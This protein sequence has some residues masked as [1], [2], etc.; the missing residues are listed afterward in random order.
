[1]QKPLWRRFY[2][3]YP[4]L[5]LVFLILF[6]GA[7]HL[8]LNHP[9][10]QRYVI[11][12]VNNYMGIQASWQDLSFNAL[13]GNFTGKDLQLTLKDKT[14]IELDRFE[15]SF[16]P[17]K[18]LVK[19]IHLRNIQA[20]GVRI[21]LSPEKKHSKKIPKN[22]KPLSLPQIQT[23]KLAKLFSMIRL[24]Q[25]SLNKV[26][27][28]IDENKTLFVENINVTSQ[29]NLYFFGRT[30]TT[31]LTHFDYRSKKLDL[32]I[33]E[34]KFQGSID[35][36]INQEGQVSKPNL[37]ALLNAQ[38]VLIGLNKKPSPWNEN[39]AW[40]NRL[41]QLIA[42]YFRQPPENRAF[43]YVRSF[44]L[45]ITLN[46]QQFVI[47]EA[48]FDAFGGRLWADVNYNLAKNLLAAKIKTERDFQLSLMPLGKAV[49]RHS[50]RWAW[51]DI[52]LQGRGIKNWRP[53]DLKDL[54]LQG[55]AQL[56]LKG[57]KIEVDGPDT[58]LNLKFLA[59]SKKVKISQINGKLLGLLTGNAQFDWQTKKLT[60]K[61]SAQGLDSQTV[62][63]LFTRQKIGGLANAKG[64]IFGELTNPSFDLELA[65]DNLSYQKLSVGNFSGRLRIKNHE[66][67][68]TGD[69][70]HGA[71]S[72][73]KLD[74]KLKEVFRPSKQTMILQVNFAQMPI[75]KVVADTQTLKGNIT[76]D[77]SLKRLSYNE[78]QASGKVRLEPFSWYEVDFQSI[79]AIVKQKDKTLWL[80]PIQ[81]VWKSTGQK[82][83]ANGALV[84][85]FDDQGYRFEGPVLQNTTIKGE[86]LKARP[87]SLPIEVVTKNH[88]LDFLTPFFDK[89]ITKSNI[90][91]RLLIDFPILHQAKPKYQAFLDDLAIEFNDQTIKL[92]A[93][94]QWRVTNQRFEFD[95][96]KIELGGLPL[97][98]RGSY[99]E[100][101]EFN[102]NLLGT[103]NT[104]QLIGWQPWLIDAS[105]KAEVKLE[106]SGDPKNPIVNGGV[107]FDKANLSFRNLRSEINRLTGHLE[108]KGNRVRFDKVKFDYDDSPIDLDGWIEWIA[109]QQILAAD[110]KI[111]AKELL[112]FEP[113]T[114]R[115]LIDGNYYLRGQGKGLT[116][117]GQAFL[118]EG[119][120]YKDYNLVENFL[121]PKTQN[122]LNKK[123]I[124]DLFSPINLSVNLK[125]SGTFEIR[126]NLTD[127]VLA[128]ELNIEGTVGN[129]IF[130]GNIN[131]VEGAIHAL[132]FD[133][134]DA[135]GFI[136]FDYKQK[137]INPY[138]EMIA[139]QEIQ[140]YEI[141]ALING[142]MDNL[143]FSLESTP[144]LN[145]KEILSLIIYGSTPDQLSTQKR[146]LF[147]RTAIASQVIGAVQRP[148]SK[149]TGLDIIKLKPNEDPFN[150]NFSKLSIG[151]QITDRFTIA[152]TTELDL[153]TA[154]RGITLEYLVLDNLLLKS[155]TDG[156]S[157]YRFDVTWRFE[158]F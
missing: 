62:F 56:K 124:P 121:K 126:N 86:Y 103:V 10:L 78:Y 65:S 112:F 25:G 80:G 8:V 136:S 60:S 142:R 154:N 76:G 110:L 137:T 69:A 9:K 116:L 83:Q 94:A 37:K 22:K 54:A 128:P 143:K 20:T 90:S 131:I 130:R 91:G 96:T 115:V 155:T 109:F 13:G 97:Q 52:E 133:F 158:L 61:L 85:R 3:F 108:L 77:Y 113:Q 148:L 32:I 102:L 12:K 71:G 150:E 59:D 120:Y 147:S 75:E 89:P 68:L 1:M 129:P 98:F 58:E 23:Q 146:N 51:L 44:D 57:N 82:E 30:V 118:V 53:V 48:T 88:H 127:L 79:S 123:K 33:P 106:I 31:Q 107:D 5:L 92:I 99:Q 145:Q 140:E 29:K 55:M 42:Q 74:L 117:S 114:W 39:P 139:T 46:R 101:K 153:D 105:G 16:Q 122:I 43:V 34:L 134:E 104:S 100:D 151:K 17:F 2:I 125:D 6:L 4:A 63:G 47:D 93:P 81:T 132:G 36:Q 156:S 50:Y 152:F 26:K 144:P 49:F 72:S 141:Q 24:D 87:F 38:K 67:S 45:P 15:F 73:A 14:K 21:Y 18:L 64:T 66:L 157:K 135:R 7:A 70:S 111:N 11:G 138:I 84:F 28:T 119:L 95:Q 35:F 41:N 19:R 27:L 40:D 149:A